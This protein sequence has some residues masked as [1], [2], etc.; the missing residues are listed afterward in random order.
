MT[1]DC[2]AAP[3]SGVNRPRSSRPNLSQLTSRW[4]AVRS[5]AAS[6]QGVMYQPAFPGSALYAAC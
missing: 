6:W 3:G 4:L 5:T 1:A 2:G